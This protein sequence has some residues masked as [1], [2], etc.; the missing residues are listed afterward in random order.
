MTIPPLAPPVHGPSP[1]KSRKRLYVV[2]GIVG[3]FLA[4]CS[5]CS[6]ASTGDEAAKS[7]GKALAPAAPT[8][9]SPAGASPATAKRDAV[10][11]VGTPA[12]D[13]NFEFTVQRVRCGLRTIGSNPYLT[14]KAQGQF[15]VVTLRVKN[16]KTEPRMLSD[17]AQQA[18]VGTS[19]FDA[20]SEA[21]MYL[22][23]DGNSVWLTTINPGNAV[24][25]KV[26]FDIPPG[27]RLTG[28]ELHDSGFSDGVAVDL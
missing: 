12:R 10:A 2:L 19:S 20:D 21:G 22:A 25:G 11:R 24:T 23:D 26:V 8:T 14:K 6:G 13:G 28:L 7:P 9:T 5:S 27:A 16:V 18:F 15:C 4:V 3:A 1:R 17:F